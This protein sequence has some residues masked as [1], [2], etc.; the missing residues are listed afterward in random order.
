MKLVISEKWHKNGE[1]YYEELTVRGL[2][3]IEEELPNGEVV[4]PK[5]GDSFI[6]VSMTNDITGQV[7][8][9]SMRLRDIVEHWERGEAPVKMP[10]A[11]SIAKS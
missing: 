2:E 5:D 11:Y 4:V 8:D 7:F 6:E 9:Y 1:E 3:S 10:A